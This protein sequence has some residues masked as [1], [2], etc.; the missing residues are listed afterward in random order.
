MKMKPR[1]AINGMSIGYIPKEWEMRS[2]PE[3]PK[4]EAEARRRR[5]DL[6]RDLPR[7][8]AGAR[9]RA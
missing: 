7:E 6:A 1:P 9:Y 4:P 2:K 8:Q 3:D 5:R